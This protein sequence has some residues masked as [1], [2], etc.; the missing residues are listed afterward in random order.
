MDTFPCFAWGCVWG[1]Q[2]KAGLLFVSPGPG[3]YSKI[4]HCAFPELQCLLNL[5]CCFLFAFPCWFSP[6]ELNQKGCIFRAWAKTASRPRPELFGKA[7]VTVK[8]FF[9]PRL[10][11]VGTGLLLG[12]R[13][14]SQEHP[15]ACEFSAAGPWVGGTKPIV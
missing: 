10:E 1:Q 13:S 6:W 14:S 7:L 2:T 9:F 15:K 4:A 8:R 12:Q 3:D 5:F 11:A